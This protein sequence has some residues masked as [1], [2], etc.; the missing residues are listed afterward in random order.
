MKIADSKKIMAS[1]IIS[2]LQSSDLY[3]TIRAR[4]FDTKANLNGVRVTEAFLDEI[5][6]NEDKYICIPLCAD[7]RGL[8]SNRTIGHMYDARTGEFHSTQIGA[9][10][11]FEKEVVDGNTYLVGQARV[12]KRNKAICKALSNL[13]ADNA[14]KFSFEITCSSYEELGDGTLLIDVD[15]KNFLEGM[16]VVTFPACEDAVALDLVAECLSKGDENMADL[17]ENVVVDTV[18][19]ENVETEINETGAEVTIAATQNFEAATATTDERKVDAVTEVAEAETVVETAEENKDP[20]EE[21][22]EEAVVAESETAELVYVTESH[23]EID[24]VH[25][26][27]VDTCESVDQRTETTTVVTTPVELAEAE[28]EDPEEEEEQEELDENA[29]CH[30]EHE[31]ASYEQ[32]IA[33]LS[34]K[35]A[36][37]TSTIDTLRT[38]VAE[39]RSAQTVIASAKETLA[40]PFMAEISLPEKYSLLGKEDKSTKHYSLLERA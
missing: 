30:K 28:D 20:E 4:L 7:V 19:A 10:R 34:S 33:E 6:E 14:L 9:F 32:L 5:V 1:A 29:A 37:M 3:L 15:P 21:N 26:Y 11:H 23:T 16:A 25:A 13:F 27:N 17:N 36:E 12:M 8:L 24:T 18:V 22:K 2:E 40:N 35:L 38:E 31:N 39:L